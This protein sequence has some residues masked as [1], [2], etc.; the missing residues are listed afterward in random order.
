MKHLAHQM[1]ERKVL[2]E[3]YADATK[4][5]HGYLLI[6]LNQATPDLFRLCTCL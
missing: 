4:K 5:P 6:D 2:E 1:G 3:A